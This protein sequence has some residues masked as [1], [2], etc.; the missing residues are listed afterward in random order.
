MLMATTSIT[1][2]FVVKDKKAFNN[3]LKTIEKVPKRTIIAKDGTS[4]SKGREILK[5]FSPR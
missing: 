2:Q 3:L 4:L 1:K 5:Q